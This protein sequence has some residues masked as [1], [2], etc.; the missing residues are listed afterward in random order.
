ML[1]VEKEGIR[2]ID[3]LKEHFPDFSGK[4]LRRI[5][6]GRGVRIDGRLELFANVKLSKGQKVECKIEKEQKHVCLDLDV[7]F[8]DES[9]KVVNKKPGQ[10][11]DASLGP[12][13]HR[14]DKETSGVLVLPKS[15]AAQRHLEKQF[16]TRGVEK[17]YDALVQG[18]F[19]QKMHVENNLRKKCVYDGQSIWC[20]AADGV[21][22]ITDFEKISIKD[23]VSYLKCFPKT[24]RTHQIRVHLAEAG[25]PILGDDHYWREEPFEKSAP[26]VMLHAETIT[27]D[28]PAS[29]DRMSFSAKRPDDF[30]PYC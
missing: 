27:F 14:L 22:A 28:H 1:I 24:G 3:F 7:I 29:G 5:V 10:V 18:E 11:C 9:I 17:V 26:R 19:P 16:R 13:V 4:K 6:D 12:L 21:E 8:E 23:G 15:D 25:Y 30:L 20:S 2:L